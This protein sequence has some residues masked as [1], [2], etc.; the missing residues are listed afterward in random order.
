MPDHNE[1]ELAIEASGDR[2]FIRWLETGTLL[3]DSDDIS[4]TGK[5]LE[6]AATGW[7]R[8]ENGNIV[9]E[10]TKVDNLGAQ[11]QSG[12]SITA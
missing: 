10:W 11:T 5:S 8:F 9:E 3:N 7:I 4:G 12:L 2:V 1:E 6:V